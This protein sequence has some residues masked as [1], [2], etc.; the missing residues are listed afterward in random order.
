[1]SLKAMSDYTFTSKYPRYLKEKKRRETWVEAVYRVRDMHIRKYPEVR[2]HVEWAFDQVLE[3]RVLGSQRALQ[4]GGVPIER[5]NARMYNCCVSFCDRMRFFQEAFWL[6]LCGCGTGFSVQT[7]HVAKLPEFHPEVLDGW[8]TMPKGQRTFV[9]PD[10]I[11]G[12]ADALGILMATFLP[13]DEFADWAGYEVV[14][15]YSLIRPKGSPLASGV[16]KAPGPEP[17]RRSLEIIRDL[18]LRRIRESRPRLRSID[19]YDIL[20][21]AS[22]AVLSGGVRRSATICLFSPEDELM[23]KAKTGNWFVENPQRG[24]SNNSV[25][26]IRN[27]TS[28]ETFNR[29]MES[30]KEFGE[31]GFVW[32]DSTELVVNPCVEIG[33]WPVCEVTGESGWQMCNLCE[34]NGGMIKTEKDFEVS[35]RAGAI[36]G[37]LQAGYTDFEYLGEIT[38][39]IVKREALLGVS[40]T[41]M[42]D[43]P[44]ILLD[45]ELQR[46]MAKLIVET[47]EWLSK[48]IGIN[49]AARSTCTK[50]AG[51]TSCLLGTASGIHAHHARDYI[52]HMQGNELEAPLQHFVMHNPH[53]VESSVWSAN[54]TDK[55]IAFCISVPPHA[56]TKKDIDAVTLLKYV[57][58]TQNNWVEAGKV[59]ER[60]TQPWLSHNVSNTINV[61]P[62]EWQAVADFIYENRDS[63][64][65]V[66]LLPSTGDLDYPQAPMVAIKTSDEL[67]EIYGDATDLIGSLIEE[68]LTLFDNN[69]WSGC[70]VVNGINP[71]REPD[72]AEPL[73]DERTFTEIIDE[74]VIN[75]LK[76]Y[77]Q[78]LS[79]K[80]W[81]D[82]VKSFS[83]YMGDDL[84][85]TCYL[86]KD[87]YYFNK[88]AALRKDYVDVDY[89]TMY[90]E[91]DETKPSETIAC[92]GGACE[93]M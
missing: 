57:K 23:L 85:K 46:K 9:I 74:M 68:G 89:S 64:A 92:G 54:N 30:V 61:K 50:P 31:P 22:D 27:K 42:M 1:M 6:L 7:H 17:L 81:V 90:E 11:E 43:N 13:H 28:Q 4:F 15:D 38:E 78:Y 14:F 26:L 75:D 60:C 21:H 93:L 18:L 35:A 34:I 48:I 91:S 51:T 53:A 16:G 3:K 83:H 70:D 2:E 24:R 39:R 33:M 44:D 58:L 40:I 10:T 36:I 29:I 59:E 37:T 87:V 73:V 56:K 76:A 88:W 65:G 80:N 79:K 49:P 72:P 25:L 84:K 55:V 82:R 8:M 20:M 19:A 32:S 67:H 69:L 52:R 66:S 86:M 45:P 41:G 71:L 5:K 62:D 12:W 47:N 77:D 63:F